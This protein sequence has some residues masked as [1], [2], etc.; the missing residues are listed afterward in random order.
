MKG[1][2]ERIEGAWEFLDNGNDTT[3]IV[4]FYVL[5]P[6]NDAAVSAIRDKVIPRYRGRLENPMTLIKTD[7][8]GGSAIPET[9]P[10]QSI[11]WASSSRRV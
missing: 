8:E 11:G 2:V 6:A 3:S 5:I 7:L 9:A 10:V 4:W 1:V